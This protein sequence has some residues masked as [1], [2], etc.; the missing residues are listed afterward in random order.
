MKKIALIVAGGSGTRMESSIPKQFLLLKNKPI[1][2]HSIKA[3]TD[4]FDD[5]EMIIVL[6][7]NFIEEGKKII[8][9]FTEAYTINFAAGGTTRFHSVQNGLK[10]VK[11]NAIIF[12][13]DAVRCLASTTLI[14][15]CYNQAL[16]KGSAIPAISATDTI[17]LVDGEKNI[18]LD[19]NN[20]R[21]IQTPQTFQST[22]LLPAF[23]QGYKDSFT[24]EA[25][26]MEAFGKEIFLTDG[27]I[28]NIKITRP[29]DLVVAENILSRR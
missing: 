20:V 14:Q 5:I 21:I 26:V 24:D 10:L 4:A 15:N 16:I 23:Q 22:I 29:I 19:R 9:D 13:H 6:P 28:E 11:E 17:R 1:L 7:E 12:I 3:F 2:W 18:L 25:S 27:E 8:S